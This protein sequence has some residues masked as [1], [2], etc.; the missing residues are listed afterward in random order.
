MIIGILSLNAK[1]MRREAESANP[2]GSGGKGWEVAHFAINLERTRLNP[3][4]V[5]HT[6][7]PMRS[8]SKSW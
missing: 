8:V 6:T 1:Q 3:F 2:L 5:V 7:E 4:G